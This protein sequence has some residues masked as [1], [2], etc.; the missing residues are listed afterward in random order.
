M[1]I[2]ISY[3]S[4]LISYDTAVS[5]IVASIVLLVFVLRGYYYNNENKERDKELFKQ[6]PPQF[7]DCPIC[8]LRLPSL[9]T[10]YRYFSCCGKRICNGCIHAPLYDN[11]GNIVDNKKC[12]FCRTPAPY[13]EKEAIEREKK[14]MEANDPIAIFNLGVYHRDGRY[15]Y[16]QDYN[17]ALELWHRSGELGN[18]QAFNS[19]G[20]TYNNGEGVEVDNEKARHYWELA[21]MK[22]NEIARYNLGVEEQNSGNVNRALKHHM[23]AARDG[24]NDSLKRI[25]EMYSNVRATKDDYTKAL[26]LYQTYLGEIKSNQRDKAAAVRDDDEFR[27]Y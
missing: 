24:N 18:A 19:I 12:A 16:Q 13:T 6:P 11:Q 2:S 10:G 26:Q 22:G 4:E 1:V 7:E 8:F 3:L 17:K 23:I 5:V 20:V 15:G 9:R 21:A 25:K 14:R 27:Y